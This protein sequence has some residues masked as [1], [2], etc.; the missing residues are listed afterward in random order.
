MG[1]IRPPDPS[2]G[3]S[4]PADVPVAIAEALDALARH[5]AASARHDDALR[6]AFE[7]RVRTSADGVERPMHA[8]DRASRALERFEDARTRDAAMREREAEGTARAVLRRA[9]ERYA[10][11]LRRAGVPPERMIVAVKSVVRRAAV[12]PDPLP[13]PEHLIP[14]IVQWCVAA[15]FAAD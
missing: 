14:D 3:T 15:Y 1:S 10:R 12:A 2:P 5:R 4:P 8:G 11:D 13:E 6:R 9:V 7:T